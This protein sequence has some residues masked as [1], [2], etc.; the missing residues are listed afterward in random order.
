[1][2][3]SVPV[4]RPS[5]SLGLAVRSGSIAR[6]LI[7]FANAVVGRFRDGLAYVNVVTCM[8]F[9]AISGSATAAVSSI[10]GFMIPLMNRMG[11]HRDF[12]ASVTIT[13]ATTGLL[14]PPSNI[15]IVYSLATFLP[16]LSMW[17]PEKLG[18]VR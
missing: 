8:L 14:I 16:A 1:M 12:N 13:A 18:F 3:S 17:L 4:A 7:D 5:S 2:T 15:M 10:G 11:N 9:G 6:R